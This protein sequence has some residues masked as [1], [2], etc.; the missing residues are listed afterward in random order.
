M[1]S[2]GLFI[3]DNGLLR[4]LPESRLATEDDLQALVEKYPVV[5]SGDDDAAADRRWLLIRREQGIA[6]ADGESDRFALDHLFV[7]QDGVPTL[8]EV[9]RA[10][11]TRAR[12]EVVAQM[13]DYA[14]NARSFLDPGTLKA[15]FEEQHSVNNDDAQAHIR[16]QLGGD[17]NP[18][19]LWEN[20][21]SNLRSGALRLIFLA[22]HIPEELRTLVEFLNEQMVAMEVIAV[23]VTSF[24]TE[25]EATV[26]RARTIGQTQA[27][28]TTKGRSPSKQWDRATWIASLRQQVEP[29]VANVAE[30]I[31]AYSKERG[32]RESFGTGQRL[33][34]VQ[35]GLKN[36]AGYV[37]PFLIYNNG[38]VEVAFQTMI[39]A[40]YPPFDSDEKR[41][42]LR[43]RLQLVRGIDLPIERIDKRP[44]FK[45]SC[46]I[47]EE[48]FQS[49]T[50]TFDWILAEARSAGS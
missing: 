28:R 46:L 8:V 24:K 7:D 13:L 12:R 9:K 37:F 2:S 40:P 31:L 30:R 32:L 3:E 20:F 10:V 41:L 39:S 49:F 14:A 18:H 42:E 26:V 27:S 48:A 17:V 16:Q 6:T 23:E 38:A 36:D 33:V 11:D 21:G 29:E 22:D 45:L 19:E 4:P 35:P 34:S 44:S 15:T 50:K 1:T 25:E 43:D 5:L 47:A